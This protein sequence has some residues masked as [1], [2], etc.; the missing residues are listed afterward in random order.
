MEI[1]RWGIIGPGRIAMQFAEAIKNVEKAKLCAVA[2][3]TREKSE[4]FAEKYNVPKI[5]DSYE[6]MA[7]SD[8]IDA[9]YIAT[10]H[11]VHL[12]CAE[13]FLKNKK[14]VL[15]EKPLCINEKEASRFIECAK[16]N[17]VFLMEAL[18]TRFLPAVREAVKMAKSGEI[19][20]LLGTDIDF[21]FRVSDKTK[22]RTYKNEL[23]GGALLDVGVYT[24]NLASML[25][26]YDCQISASSL[27]E[28]NV[29]VYTSMKL[30]YQNAI[31]NLSCAICARKPCDAYIYGTDGYIH[32]TS[33]YTAKEFFLVK[34]DEKT[35]FEYPYIGNGF[36]EE[37]IEA[38]NCILDGKTESSIMSLNDSYNIT[39]QMDAIRKL[40]GVKFFQ[41][42]L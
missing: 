36:E 40:I 4:A 31:A 42:Q 15:C 38:T 16:E 30:K 41:D 5:F 7:Q 35:A 33:F 13:I 12:S 28:N 18:W 2:S 34:G 11:P 39:K 37:I 29:D 27:N 26:G 6:E 10:I 22:S 19:G 25:F 14:H 32:L 3:R 9:V 17:G 23:A 20:E 24:L 1:V 8:E 21:S